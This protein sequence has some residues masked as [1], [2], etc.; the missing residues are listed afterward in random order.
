M[1]LFD[2]LLADA[3]PLP[4]WVLIPAVI[5]VFI[6]SMLSWLAFTNPEFFYTS[7]TIPI[8]EYGFMLLS[9]GG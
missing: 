7:M 2:N 4:W 9:W 5:L 3:E 1:N 6:Y 8:P